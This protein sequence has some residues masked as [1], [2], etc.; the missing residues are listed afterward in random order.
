[1]D[2]NSSDIAIIQS[3]PRSRTEE[4][5]SMAPSGKGRGI[6]DRGMGHDHLG[7][8]RAPTETIIFIKQAEKVKR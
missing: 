3:T 6:A 5:H 8:G 2:G 7:H 4:G 1:M